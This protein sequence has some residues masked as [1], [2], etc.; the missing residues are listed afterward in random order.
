MS[1]LAA[2]IRR[3]EDRHGRCPGCAER[4]PI[5]GYSCPSRTW[6]P[7]PDE[8]TGPCP[9]CGE[10]REVIIVR[11]AFDWFRDEDEGSPAGSVQSEREQQA[12]SSGPD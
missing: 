3:L 5:L 6:L 7:A 4:A 2:R 1:R 12:R 11:V 10:P 9:G 8:D